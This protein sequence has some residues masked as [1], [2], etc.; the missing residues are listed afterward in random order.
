[1]NCRSSIIAR[2]SSSAVAQGLPVLPRRNKPMP[3]RLRVFPGPSLTPETGGP[4]WRPLAKTRAKS[5]RF[6]HPAGAVAQLGER[7]VRNEEVRGSTPL[8]ST[9]LTA[10]KTL[11]HSCKLQRRASRS[12]P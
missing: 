12:L 11:K 2:P 6:T 1:M 9:S 8:G 5:A 7:L 3:T 4:K 10:G